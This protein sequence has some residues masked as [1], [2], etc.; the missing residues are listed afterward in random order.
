MAARIKIIGPQCFHHREQNGTLRS[1]CIHCAQPVACTSPAQ[2]TAGSRGLG[3]D[4]DPFFGFE[5]AVERNLDLQRRISYSETQRRNTMSTGLNRTEPIPKIKEWQQT[6]NRT[7][8][9]YKYVGETESWVNTVRSEI[10]QDGGI[11]NQHLNSPFSMIDESGVRVRAESDD[12]NCSLLEAIRQDLHRG[13]PNLTFSLTQGL[14]LTQT[15]S[16]LFVPI[17]LRRVSVTTS[18]AGLGADLSEN[19]MLTQLSPCLK[20]CIRR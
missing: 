17:V 7:N 1:D 4:I 10:D 13:T 2:H 11:Q 5:A 20:P 19:Q 14:K 9:A 12:S 16:M 18:L 8:N 3:P 15:P 6:V